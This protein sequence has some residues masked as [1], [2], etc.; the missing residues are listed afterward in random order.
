MNKILFLMPEAKSHIAKIIQIKN[1]NLKDLIGII[2][3]RLYKK[4]K[5]LKKIDILQ[6]IIK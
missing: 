1:L 4:E 3:L 5:K 6:L 2:N